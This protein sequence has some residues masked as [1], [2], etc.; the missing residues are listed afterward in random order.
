VFPLHITPAIS[1][2][3]AFPTFINLFSNLVH[4]KA[5]ITVCSPGFIAWQALWR[6]DTDEKANQCYITPRTFWFRS[7]HLIGCFT[8]RFWCCWYRVSPR[9]RLQARPLIE[10]NNGRMATNI[11]DYSRQWEKPQNRLFVILLKRNKKQLV[12]CEKQNTWKR[13]TCEN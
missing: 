2:F 6:H 7:H 12:I 5:R 11:H 8:M 10:C 4:K 9:W 13:K 1:S 3:T